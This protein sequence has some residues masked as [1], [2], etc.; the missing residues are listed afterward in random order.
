MIE[1]KHLYAR[2]RVL[3]FSSRVFQC[4]FICEE[5]S[6]DN[7]IQIKVLISNFLFKPHLLCY[8]AYV[9]FC[10][11]VLP[12]TF[13]A[14]TPTSYASSSSDRSSPHSDTATWDVGPITTGNT[15][16]RSSECSIVE[17]VSTLEPV[18]SR[19]PCS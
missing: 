10:F 15:T 1:K 6:M 8:D 14:G 18:I 4:E 17:D 9:M 13:S 16:E 2:V 7:Q 12:P 5:W 11:S 3:D 19:N